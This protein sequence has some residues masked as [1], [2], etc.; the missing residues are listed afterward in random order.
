MK[1]YDCE[2]FYLVA[3]FFGGHAVCFNIQYSHECITLY[4]SCWTASP[5]KSASAAREQRQVAGLWP[6][7]GTPH[8]DSPPAHSRPQD[9]YSTFY[10]PLTRDL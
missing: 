6:G 5:V 10:F 7:H 1:C 4:P 8:R 3:T 9:S 2:P